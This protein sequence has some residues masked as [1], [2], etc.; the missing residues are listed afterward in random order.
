[1][2]KIFGRTANHY[3][4]LANG[5]G[6]NNIVNEEGDP[7]SISKTETFVDGSISDK[8]IILTKLKFFS[9]SLA[10]RLQNRNLV[11]LN[12]SINI[13]YGHNKKS[14]I[15]HTRQ[16]KLNIPVFTENIIYEHAK[17]LLNNE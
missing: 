4:D 2:K 17:Y 11:S 9:R 8:S 1:L 15:S 5:I 16:K 6:N 14:K 13:A 3:I 7:K 12:V 10:I